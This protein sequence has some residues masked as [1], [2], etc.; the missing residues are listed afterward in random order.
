MTQ[1]EKV[2][3]QPRLCLPLLAG[4]GRWLAGTVLLLAVS[5]DTSRAASLD[6]AA[7]LGHNAPVLFNSG[8]GIGLPNQE[9]GHRRESGFF[10]S[11]SSHK[12][13]FSM[14]GRG[15]GIYGCAGSFLPVD[16]P[17]YAPTSPDWSRDG[18]F[19]PKKEATMP[20]ITRALSR[21]FIAAH[22]VA[23]FATQ[24]EAIAF[25]RQYLAQTGRAV[26]VTPVALGFDVIGGAV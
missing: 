10:A 12:C 3:N 19:K 15:G 8:I 24:T 22:P 9:G 14:V 21:L 1:S 5:C 2:R 6:R 26:A 20:S 17:R 13:A 25:A 4:A 7:G 11:V 16:Q 23:R 18:G